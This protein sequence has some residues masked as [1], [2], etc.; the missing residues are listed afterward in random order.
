MGKSTT[1][2]MF[3]DAGCAVWDADAAV[4][5]LYAKGGLAVPGIAM[6]FPD[7]VRQ[8]AVS[9][10]AL[11]DIIARDPTALRQIEAIVHPLVALD[12]KAFLADVQADIAVLDIPLLF[13]TGGEKAVDAVACVIVPDRIQVERVMARGTLSEAQ[14]S[15]IREKQMPAVKKAA[16]ADYVIPTDTLEVA[17][18]QVQN[19][20]DHI[21]KRLAN[22]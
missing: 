18:A 16:R 19:V 4:H 11:K 12:R 21:K 17:R 1:A 5:R 3:A 7:A 8:A 2:Q 22:A 9:R 20:I 10:D 13:E 6:K 14:F 15:A